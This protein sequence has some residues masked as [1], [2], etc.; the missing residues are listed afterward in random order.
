MNLCYVSDI[1]APGLAMFASLTDTQ[2]RNR[3]HPE[4]ALIIVESPKVILT[5]LSRGLVPVAL[6]CEEKHITG[7]AAAVIAQCPA[8]MPIYT[9][10]RE[11]L[12]NLTGYRLTRG[13][14]CAMRR[15]CEPPAQAVCPVSSGRIAVIDGVVDTTNIGAIFR[16]AAAL[17]M[18]A[19]LLTRSSCDPYNRRAIRV[20]MG[21]VFL[22][23]WA[24]IDGDVNDTLHTLGY[25]TVSMALRS[26]SVTLDAKELKQQP[27]LAIILG[28]EGDG[29]ADRVIANSDFVAKIPMSH[30]VDSLNVAAASAIAFYELTRP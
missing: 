22:V 27:L 18:D 4:D 14:L 11:T 10:S 24:W 1:T 9:G 21:S 2:L 6:L 23:P 25:K 30:G 20:S 7:D 5:A 16:S 26:D 29:L 28:T 3:L 19:V 17:G 13:V 15:P 12:Q 8:D